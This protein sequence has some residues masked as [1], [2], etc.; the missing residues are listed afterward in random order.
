[1]LRTATGHD[2]LCKLIM[3]FGVF[4]GRLLN[5]WIYPFVLKFWSYKNKYFFQLLCVIRSQAKI[6]INLYHQCFNQRDKILS[7]AL[8]KVPFGIFYMG[9][10]KKDL[11]F[12]VQRNFIFYWLLSTESCFWSYRSHLYDLFNLLTFHSL[13]Y[14]NHHARWTI[15]LRY[16]KEI[17]KLCKI[18]SR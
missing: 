18:D 3:I 9:V 12:A 2:L 1:M 17:I 4:P 6:C 10:C 13:S 5:L 15:S 14:H 16:L 8:L 7:N 11:W